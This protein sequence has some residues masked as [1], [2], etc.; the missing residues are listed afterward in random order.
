MGG[1]CLSL[2][3]VAKLGVNRWLVFI[4]VMIKVL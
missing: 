4:S 1:W 3:R 2:N